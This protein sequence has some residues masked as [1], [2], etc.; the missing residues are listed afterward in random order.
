VQSQEILPGSVSG[1]KNAEL[2]YFDHHLIIQERPGW[3][4]GAV[5]MIQRGYVSCTKADA[6]GR[7]HGRRGEAA[8]RNSID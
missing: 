3:L 5:T 7:H 1:K 8:S 4:P 2:Y 6:A